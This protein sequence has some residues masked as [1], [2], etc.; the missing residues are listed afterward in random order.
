MTESLKVALVYAA[1]LDAL[2]SKALTDEE[3]PEEEND[4]NAAVP[5]L[6]A[7]QMGMLFVPLAVLTLAF[8]RADPREGEDLDGRLGELPTE[9]SDQA[10]QI[11]LGP[12][13]LVDAVHMLAVFR[14]W[15][16]RLDFAPIYSADE[17]ETV[18]A[19][20]TEQASHAVTAIVDDR[21]A[22][23]VGPVTVH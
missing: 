12:N 1:A 22:E 16:S 10:M 23:S 17:L 14:L 15:E 5:M 8:S 11:R 4:G 21:D 3:K 18:L 9:L 6:F 13:L 20:V 7:A 19:V 2:V